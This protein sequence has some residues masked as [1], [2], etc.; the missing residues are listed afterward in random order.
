MEDRQ[1]N[2]S[3]IGNLCFP[4][5]FK[6]TGN[7][8]FLFGREFCVQRDFLIKSCF[9]TALNDHI[10]LAVGNKRIEMGK[11]CMKLG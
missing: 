3:R 8:P 11:H 4:C 9:S 7:F 1:F 10:Y 2:L 5:Y 6:E